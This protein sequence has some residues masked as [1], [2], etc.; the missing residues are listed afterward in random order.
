MRARVDQNLVECWIR[1]CR[2]ELRDGVP[3]RGCLIKVDHFDRPPLA[4]ID[5]KLITLQRQF[6]GAA[7]DQLRDAILGCL[8][9]GAESAIFQNAA[10]ASQLAIWFDFI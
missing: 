8:K 7:F 6:V 5:D 3:P 1:Q 4:E 10:D 2:A 9:L